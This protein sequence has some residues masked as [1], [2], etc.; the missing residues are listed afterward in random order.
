MGLV[1]ANAWLL[2]EHFL[3]RSEDGTDEFD[4]FE[5][6]TTGDETF[7]NRKAFLETPLETIELSWTRPDGTTVVVVGVQEDF[8]AFG[9][10][11]A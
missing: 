3:K 6:E 11:V 2:F 9:L 8:E 5:D 10:S 4:A 7:L 1:D